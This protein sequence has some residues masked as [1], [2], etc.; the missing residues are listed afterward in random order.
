MLVLVSV[1]VSVVG[2]PASPVVLLVEKIADVV[3]NTSELDVDVIELLVEV[4]RLVG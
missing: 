4:G 1:S 2:I 3:V